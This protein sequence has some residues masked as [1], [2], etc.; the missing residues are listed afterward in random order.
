[1]VIVVN[2]TFSYIVVEIK[3]I[4]EKNTYLL[5]VTDKLYDIKLDRE[6]LAFQ[7]HNFSSDRH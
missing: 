1:M 6:H 7:T 5:Q 3:S 2:T 4:Q